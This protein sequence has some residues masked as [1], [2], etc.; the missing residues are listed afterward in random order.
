MHVLIAAM[1]MTVPVQEG[2]R[3]LSPDEARTARALFD[4]T[5]ANW[6]VPCAT[7]GIETIRVAI[8]VELD[9][10]GRFIREPVL[11]RPQGTP[12]YRITADSALRALHDA[13]PF[14][15]P[16]GFAGGRYRPTFVPGRVCA[17]AG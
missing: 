4:Q 5:Y 7:P 6:Q 11:V 13:E 12:A 10:T 14:D 8:E 9:A 16:A 1:L 15:V 17:K 2:R 3:A